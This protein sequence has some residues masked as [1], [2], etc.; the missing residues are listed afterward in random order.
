MGR[1]LLCDVGWMGWGEGGG[2]VD[3]VGIMRFCFCHL[4]EDRI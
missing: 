4:S 1:I 3:S 2:I